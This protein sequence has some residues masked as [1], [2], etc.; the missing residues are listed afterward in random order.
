MADSIVTQD[1]VEQPRWVDWLDGAPGVALALVWGFAEG[2]LFFVVPDVLISLAALMRPRRAWRH[3]LAAIFGAVLGGGLLFHWAESSPAS[4]QRAVGQVP[5][6]TTRMFD[7]V[8]EGYRAHGMGAVYRGPLTGTPYKIYAVEAPEFV[9]RTAFL[10]ATV[11]ARGER[12]LLV[13]IVFAVAGA[14]L[15]RY[16]GRTPSHIA[17]RHAAFWVL[18]YAFYWSRIALER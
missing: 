9:G 1:G 5:F 11:P 12:F 17:P 3:L 15:R 4:A 14:A 16:L 13:W 6:V 7:H 10:L 8:R 18:F 2:T